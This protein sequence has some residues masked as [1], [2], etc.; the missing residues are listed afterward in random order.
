MSRRGVVGVD[1]IAGGRSGYRLAVGRGVDVDE[2]E[3]L[4]ARAE[5]RGVEPTGA[6]A[7]PASN[8]LEILSSG[9][10]L[11]DEPVPRAVDLGRHVQRLLRRGRGVAGVDGSG[12]SPGALGR[13]LRRHRCRPLDEEAHR[14]AC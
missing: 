11:E 6:R 5:R 7:H 10:V 14:D 1:V 8:A 13:A 2:A 12:R 3:Q 9:V 4:V